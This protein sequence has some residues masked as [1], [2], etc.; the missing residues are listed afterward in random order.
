MIWIIFYFYRVKIIIMCAMEKFLNFIGKI[1]EINSNRIFEK[2]YVSFVFLITALFWVLGTMKIVP[3]YSGLVA[4][5][6]IS[7]VSL[8]LLNDFKYFIPCVI[9]FIFANPEGYKS[10]ELPIHMLVC[11]FSMV[12]VLLIFSIVNFKKLSLKG[13]NK[14][15]ISF[16]YFA[17]FSFLPLSYHNLITSEVITLVLVYFSYILYLGIYIFFLMNMNGDMKRMTFKSCEMIGILLTIQCISKVYLMHLE[18]PNKPI[19]DMWYF[20][21]W[22]LCNEAGILMCFSLPFLFSKTKHYSK[23]YQYIFLTIEIALF[24]VGMLVTTSRGTYLFGFISLLILS[25]LAFAFNKHKVK[26]F[27]SVF[28]AVILIL[29][30]IQVMFGIEKFFNEIMEV[31]FRKK[32]DSNGRYQLYATAITLWSDTPLSVLFGKGWV[33]ERVHTMTYFGIQDAYMVYHSTFFETLACYGAIGV[34]VLIFHFYERYKQLFKLDKQEFF[35]I[36]I[37]FIIVDLYGMIDNSYHYYYYMIP[38]VIVMASLDAYKKHEN[39]LVL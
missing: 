30:S 36:F 4:L 11:G 33:A 8:I 28:I 6:I 7:S 15:F 1:R 26:F 14:S 3:F 27:I 2:I 18:F 34:F 37:G 9:S 17:I 25:V 31:V 20:L 10:N 23:W 39:A 35:I 22:G 32:L 29:S 24:V 5:T 21:G 38:L 19:L 12:G 16:I 13:K